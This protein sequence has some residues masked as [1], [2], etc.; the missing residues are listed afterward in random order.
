MVCGD[1][2]H[3]PAAP[4]GFAAC[5]SP[6]CGRDGGER[7]GGGARRPAGG[8]AGGFNRFISCLYRVSGVAFRSTRSVR[9]DR[10]MQNM[11][12]HRT[13][14]RTAQ[15]PAAAEARTAAFSIGQVVCH[16]YYPIRGVIFDVDAQYSNPEEWWLSIPED[17]RPDKNQP[18]YHLFAENDQ[19]AYVA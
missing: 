3:P 18:F 10:H 7:D 12:L 1:F 17:V 16:R 5:G 19:S 6:P 8:S 2:F 9:K 14:S 15:P 13:T 4:R 11:E